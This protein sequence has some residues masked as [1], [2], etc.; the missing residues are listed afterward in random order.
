M[1]PID[2]QTRQKYESTPAEQQ[3]QI[4]AVFQC[5]LPGLLDSSPY[6]LAAL[7]ADLSATAKVNGVTPDMLTKIY[8]KEYKRDYSVKI[9]DTDRGPTISGTKTTVYDVMEMADNG[10][11]FFFICYNL[12]LIPPQVEI[13]LEYIEEHRARLEPELKEIQETLA[14]RERYYRALAEKR[15]RESPPLPMTPL[16]KAV[17]EIIDK[18]RR[19]RG[20]TVPDRR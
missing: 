1:I 5:L 12:D 14:E 17:Y 20:E 15:K 2:E 10:A 3:D 9:I 16:R 18:N 8:P 6:K 11:E 13:A 7:I 19:A 4:Q